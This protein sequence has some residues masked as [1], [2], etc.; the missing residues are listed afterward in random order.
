[1][2]SDDD[3]VESILFEPG[4]LLA[5]LP[6][7][8][9]HVGMSTVSAE[10]SRRLAAAHKEQGQEYVA[11]PVLG[12]PDAA[13]AAQLFILA[14]GPASRIEQCRPLFEA[15]GRRTFVFGDD[16]GAA[17]IV[18]LSV[19]FLILT[20]I[21]GMAESFALVR[22]SGLDV[23][24][25]LHFLTESIFSAPVYKTYGPL[26][27]ADK[28]DQVGCKLTLGFKDNRLILAAGEQAAA[29]MPLASL[30]HDRFVSAIAHGLGDLDW[31]AIAR[32]SYRDANL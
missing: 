21:E 2:L 16:P 31:T 26:V 27:A 25:F 18:K 7:G 24:Q 5:A 17:N 22:K 3:A 8:T 23:D 4:N 12:R 11:A 19:N 1:M 6:A 28:F 32:I 13:A 29:P 20:L 9:L 14:A 10:L 15:M 30:V